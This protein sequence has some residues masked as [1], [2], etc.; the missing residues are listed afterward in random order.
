[1]KFAYSADTYPNKWWL[2]HAKGADI[3]IHESFLPPPVLVT[4][5]KFPVEDALNVAWRAVLRVP[6]LTADASARS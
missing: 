6:H 5:Q 3:S 4:K 2:E 1:M